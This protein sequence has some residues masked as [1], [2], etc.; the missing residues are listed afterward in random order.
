M[1]H[2]VGI[3]AAILSLVAVFS[4]AQAIEMP[5]DSL[6]PSNVGSMIEAQKGHMEQ[7]RMAYSLKGE[8]DA[9]Q[10]MVQ[11]LNK[12]ETARQLRQRGDVD[13]ALRLLLQIREEVR[14]LN[15][16]QGIDPFNPDSL[17]PGPDPGEPRPPVP[18]VI[19]STGTVIWPDSTSILPP[20]IFP[21]EI[22]DVPP[23]LDSAGVAD[24]IDLA[25]VTIDSFRIG[26]TNPAAIALLDQADAIL[27]SARIMLASGDVFLV[28]RIARQLFTLIQSAVKIESAEATLAQ[29]ITRVRAIIATLDAQMGEEQYAAT[30][31]VRAG[32][33]ADSAQAQLDREDIP[34]AAGSV[35]RVRLVLDEARTLIQARGAFALKLEW[36]ERQA[37]SL[38][39]MVSGETA[40]SVV[41]HIERARALLDSAS[42]RLDRGQVVIAYRAGEDADAILTRARKMIR[43]R[44]QIASR[45]GGDEALV[46]SLKKWLTD[47]P[48][49]GT[50]GMLE[51]A[52]ALADT[53]RARLERGEVAGAEYALENLHDLANHVKEKN[54]VREWTRN[55]GK[56][57]QKRLTNMVHMADSV[58]NAKAEQ[59]LTQASVS[60]DSMQARLDDGRI[61]GAMVA[62]HQAR[63]EMSR[64]RFVMTADTVAARLIDTLRVRSQRILADL[65][66]SALRE[67]AILQLAIHFADSARIAL[68]GGDVQKA[69][70]IAERTVNAVRHLVATVPSRPPIGA[71]RISAEVPLD[72]SGAVNLEESV[73][74]LMYTIGLAEELAATSPPNERADALIGDAV[75]LLEQVIVAID[76][77]DLSGIDVT[78]NNALDT[79]ELAVAVLRGDAIDGEQDDPE[80]LALI[81]IG[82]KAADQTG[83]DD[84]LGNLPVD[85]AVSNAPNPF[86][87]QTSIMVAMPEAGDARLVIYNML[88]QE[89]RT[90]VAGRLTAGVH[91]FTW[92][93]R[94]D[95]GSNVASGV[96]FARLVTAK[97]SVVN[98][99][100]LVR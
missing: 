61:V 100:M 46:D 73:N 63:R 31:L 50:E 44:E 91:T 12:L 7:M 10:A 38:A 16:A 55:S 79:A 90:L 51:S 5:S 30:L 92:N 39:A 80:T 9:E 81:A 47:D 34:R 72:P 42:A 64:A 98:R 14:A 87:P 11:L 89:V 15:E 70:R 97:R 65:P 29:E 33:L 48:I 78:I 27:D 45:I 52:A 22:G 96:Y 6:R 24:L 62:L 82:E 43:E 21:G 59:L 26:M 83:I 94:N 58:D 2:S 35:A 76:E 4:V 68:E 99:M 25:E 69:L 3:K 20:D 49:P 8:Q 54:T 36:L 41:A 1:K 77:G 85:Y 95:R 66:D 71:L 32:V 17:S 67:R 84:G 93:A 23:V 37:D 56:M 28:D 40:P 57:V 74:V 13:G 19:D 53:V 60:M 88:G 75:Y 18:P 86:N